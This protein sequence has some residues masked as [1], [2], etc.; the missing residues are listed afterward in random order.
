MHFSYT[1]QT[2]NHA[3]GNAEQSN[4][5]LVH[6]PIFCFGLGCYIAF[7]AFSNRVHSYS[8]SSAGALTIAL[9]RISDKRA[10]VWLGI[11][12]FVR[13]KD[14]VIS[15]TRQVFRFISTA[16]D[17]SSLLQLNHNNKNSIMRNK[18][19]LVHWMLIIYIF[20]LAVSFSSLCL[21]LCSPVWMN[22]WN[23]REETKMDVCFEGDILIYSE[24]FS[25][26]Y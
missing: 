19:T 18:K 4:K 26:A 16:R 21:C 10:K 12:F 8:Y 23:R 13:E 5:L 22:E 14:T 17:A 25:N 3:I 20:G 15:T 2:H 6:S 11:Q 9:L 1:A 7:L 24:S